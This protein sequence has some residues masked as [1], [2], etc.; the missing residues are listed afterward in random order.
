MPSELIFI[1]WPYKKSNMTRFYHISVEV[2]FV[3]QL[4]SETKSAAGIID[5]SNSN[6]EQQELFLILQ[7]KFISDMML[8]Y[9][10][11]QKIVELLIFSDSANEY[12]QSIPR[13]TQPS[14]GAS[15]T[16]FLS[17]IPAITEDPS[18]FLYQL[19][20]KLQGLVRNEDNLKVD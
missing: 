1:L 18:S 8:R 12:W 13:T 9:N 5:T 15:L 19:S 17:S 3:L 6:F 11:F 10:E 16:Q 7:T 4:F 14:T 2:F 20:R